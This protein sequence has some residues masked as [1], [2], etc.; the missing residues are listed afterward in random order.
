MAIRAVL[1]LLLF[2]AGCGGGKDEMKKKAQHSLIK[3]SCASCSFTVFIER[4]EQ[5]HIVAETAY[6]KKNGDEYYVRFGAGED[7]EK[8]IINNRGVYMIHG[9][10]VRFYP[11]EDPAAVFFIDRIFINNGEK[12]GAEVKLP[13]EKIDGKKYD[14]SVYAVLKK[15]HGIHI[16]ASVTEFSR[17]GTVS[18][19]EVTAPPYDAGAGDSVIMMPGI[20]QSLKIRDFKCKKISREVFDPQTYAVAGVR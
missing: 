14:V 18:K 5:G 20:R 10:K 15:T 3:T 4:E 13:E 6:V 16:N 19:I 17:R 8:M 1:V 9:G 11:R 12:R 7:A 2:C